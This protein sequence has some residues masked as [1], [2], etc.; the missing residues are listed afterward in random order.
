MKPDI[1]QVYFILR[2]WATTGKPQ[3]Y[4]Q[5]SLDYYAQTN[6]WFEPHGSWD[7]TLGELNTH[8][9]AMGA[10]ALSALVILQRNNEPGA[11]FWGCAPNVPRRPKDNI[12]RI[13]QWNS[14]VRLV[15]DFKWP[16]VL[17]QETL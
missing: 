8:L 2:Q 1:H 5:L 13:S 15:I 10:P 14:I 12:E 17:P 4:T 6:N 16:L 3:S 9:A 7:I 11:S